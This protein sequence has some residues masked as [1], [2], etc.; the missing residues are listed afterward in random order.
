MTDATM[1]TGSSAND[2][3]AEK[4]KSSSK[5]L[6]MIGGLV[7]LL[8]GGAGGYF[9]FMAPKSSATEHKEEKKVTGFLEI[10]E[11]LIGMAADTAQPNIG[12]QRFM[13]LHV[14]LEVA[15]TKKIPILQALQPRIEDMFQVYLRE[16]RPA[17]L[18]GS[19]AIF[20]LK[21]ELLRRVN[22]AVS[23]ERVD[24]VLIKELLLQ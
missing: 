4:P 5:K 20:R 7:V 3:G 19:A 1:D 15:D 21:E 14:M 9:F 10:K 12:P 13:K 17:D 8:G 2:K 23:P 24:A 11:L 22:L 6:I 16:L 18:Q